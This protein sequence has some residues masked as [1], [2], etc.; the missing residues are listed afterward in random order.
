MAYKQAQNRKKRLMKTYRQTKNSYGAGVWF[1]ED[2]G[3]YIKY[4][5]SKTPGY[6]KYLRKISNRKIRRIYNIGNF[7]NYKKHFDY[8]W[9][10]F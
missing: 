1:N 10:L 9:T 8:W 4:T 6:A 5:A 7:S 3:R 2:T